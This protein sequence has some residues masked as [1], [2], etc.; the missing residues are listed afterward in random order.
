MSTTFGILILVVVLLLYV[1]MIF[2]G[3]TILTI[4]DKNERDTEIIKMIGSK[5]VEHSEDIV[6]IYESLNLIGDYIIEGGK[7]NDV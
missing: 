7:Q 4:S 1:A 3:K 5:V 2:I 6:K